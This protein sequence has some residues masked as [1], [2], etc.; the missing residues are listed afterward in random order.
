MKEKIYKNG[1]WLLVLIIYGYIFTFG[2]AGARRRCAPTPTL[3]NLDSTRAVDG[4]TGFARVVWMRNGEVTTSNVHARTS[5]IFAKISI[6]SPRPLFPAQTS[7]AGPA[8]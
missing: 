7:Q 2:R 8:P 5:S 4:F 1:F 6:F 3:Q